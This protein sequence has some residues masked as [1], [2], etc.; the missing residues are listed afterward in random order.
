MVRANSF[1][2]VCELPKR[3]ILWFA[4]T[5]G[6]ERWR[7]QGFYEVGLNDSGHPATPN[8]AGIKKTVQVSAPKQAAMWAVAKQINK[9]FK[10]R[11]KPIDKFIP[12]LISWGLLGSDSNRRFRSTKPD[13]RKDK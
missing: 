9:D 12:I 10:I 1:S 11:K 5:L 4:A 2:T 7:C 6:G 13:Q 3:S 8:Y